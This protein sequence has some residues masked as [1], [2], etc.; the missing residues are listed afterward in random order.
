MKR[1]IALTAVTAFMFSTSVQYG[2]CGTD[3]GN[4]KA[5]VECKCG[6]D[7]KGAACKCGCQKKKDDKS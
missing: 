4:G 7:C 2:M 1:L 3:K 6:K 5:K